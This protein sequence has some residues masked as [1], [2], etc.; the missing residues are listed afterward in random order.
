M[1]SDLPVYVAGAPTAPLCEPRKDSALTQTPYNIRSIRGQ[2][3]FCRGSR[4]GCDALDYRRR[5][6][7]HHSG[8]QT[9]RSAVAITFVL[10]R[11]HSW[12]IKKR[13]GR[14]NTNV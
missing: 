7:C 14:I 3:I 6:A 9:A 4:A 5:H 10:I 13:A 12:L 1:V 2:T 11:V 8:K